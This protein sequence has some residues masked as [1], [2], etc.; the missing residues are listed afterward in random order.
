MAKDPYRY[1]RVEARELLTALGKGLI[2]LEAF[3][4]P[5]AE[6][7]MQRLAHTLKGAARVVKLGAIADLAHTFEDALRAV[8]GRPSPEQVDGLLRIVDA[9]SIELGRIDEPA[10]VAPKPV[11]V[12]TAALEAKQPPTPVFIAAPRPEA[13]DMDTILTSV[14]DM[15]TSLM[16]LQQA[17]SELDAL[18][19]LAT[20]WTET[21]TRREGA[22]AQRELSAAA[23][24]KD[25]LAKS[26]RAVGQGVEH[27]RRELEQARDAAERL[28]LVS[29]E[30]LVSALER[31]AREVARATGKQVT[32]RAHGAD[33]RL[34][35]EVATQVQQALVQIVRNAVAHGIEVPSARQAAGKPAAGQIVIEVKRVDRSVVFRCSDDGAGIDVATVEVALRDKGVIAATERPDE[36]RVLSLLLGA[37]VSTAREITESAGRGVGMDVVRETVAKLRG[38]VRIESERGR[39][40]TVS[41]VVPYSLA[42][43][44]VLFLRADDVAAAI[45]LEVVIGARRVAASEIVCAGGRDVVGTN[46]SALPLC[47]LGPLLASYPGAQPN[48]TSGTRSWS[49]VEV[50]HRGGTLGLAV[51]AL[52]GSGSVVVRPTPPLTPASPIVGGLYLDAS[53]EPHVLIDCEAIAMDHAATRI[54]VDKP[55]RLPILVI[56]DSL[57]TRM[58]EKTIL[59]SAGYEVDLAVSGEDGL[60]KAHAQR[61]CLFL[62]DVE[63][64]GIDGYT[65]VARTRADPATNMVPAI[66]VTS[67][68]SPEDIQRGKDAGAIDYVVKGEFDQGAL[69]GRIREL[70]G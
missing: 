50:R 15:S 24:L 31:I 28:R 67:R 62:V 22:R 45:P 56:D 42:S 17:T 41:L 12:P 9:M 27:M 23:E 40:T 11:P 64:P 3:A 57:T 29:T 44:D 2:A 60:E 69:L 47:R 1:F 53:G 66:L 39:G 68:G 26:A 10:P 16:G 36:Q 13:R 61:Y 38:D 8:A 19:A 5:E 33:A 34:E 59:E 6:R 52:L 35:A 48:N 25:R 49:I 51:D 70:V 21:V 65:F 32:L 20:R 58:L 46:G 18:V 30:A 14:A 54:E 37:G 63:M 7:T 4:D 43:V 55:M